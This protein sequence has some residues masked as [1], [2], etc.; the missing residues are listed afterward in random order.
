MIQ[1]QEKD[2][3]GWMYLWVCATLQDKWGLKWAL[4]MPG[5][6]FELV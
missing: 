4:D 1:V 5:S 6:C 2:V 3:E